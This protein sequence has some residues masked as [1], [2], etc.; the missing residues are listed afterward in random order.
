MLFRMCGSEVGARKSPIRSS[1]QQGPRCF[2]LPHPS[3]SLTFTPFSFLFLCLLLSSGRYQL[4][5]RCPLPLTWANVT[6]LT[7]SCA[8]QGAAIRDGGGGS[9][10]M[11][12]GGKRPSMD[13]SWRS[14]NLEGTAN[15]GSSAIWPRVGAN[16]IRWKPASREIPDSRPPS[17][18]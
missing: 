4:S 17:P 16:Q 10:G 1:R 6:L 18:L 15:R 8:G 14:G 13:A 3:I 12:G 9:F 11:R 2:S 5:L 7:E